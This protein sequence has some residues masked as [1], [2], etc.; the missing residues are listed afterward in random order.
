MPSSILNSEA[1]EAEMARSRPRTPKR[2]P[3]SARSEIEGRQW[4]LDHRAMISGEMLGLLEDSQQINRNRAQQLDSWARSVGA[5]F[6]LWRS[7]FLINPEKIR[8]DPAAP[9]H[10]KG[11]KENEQKKGTDLFS[12]AGRQGAGLIRNKTIHG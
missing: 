2:V 7:V 12:A 9:R 5:A 11:I 1:Q 10:P 6:S 4:V 8:Q 3:T